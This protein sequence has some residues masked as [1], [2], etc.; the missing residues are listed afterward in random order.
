MKILERVALWLPVLVLAFFVIRL[1]NFTCDLPVVHDLKIIPKI[2]ERV[3]IKGTVQSETSRVDPWVI[4]LDRVDSDFKINSELSYIPGSMHVSSVNTI[5]KTDWLSPVR[6]GLSYA[7]YNSGSSVHSPLRAS[8]LY[9]PIS[10]KNLEL[11]AHVNTNLKMV[12]FGPALL[13]RV[14]NVSAGVSY[15][16]L[17][18][19]FSLTVAFKPF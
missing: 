16:V 6:L 9:A 13:Y 14:R 11:A 10:Y 3:V 2:S 12:D 7:P 15:D 19:G 8:V 17:S 4:V 1:F 5:H 18:R